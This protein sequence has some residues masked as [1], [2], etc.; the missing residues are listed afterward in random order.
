MRTWV[1]VGVLAVLVGLWA[2]VERGVVWVIRNGRCGESIGCEHEITQPGE[3]LSQWGALNEPGW[4]RSSI[5]EYERSHIFGFGFE[6]KEWD[7]YAIM[8]PDVFIG[9][10]I[11]DMGYIS[12]IA[13]SVIPLQGNINGLSFGDTYTAMEIGQ[14]SPKL[15]T[16][17][18]DGI[19]IAYRGGANMSILA[20]QEQQQTPGSEGPGVP[21]LKKKISLEW[22]AYANNL[23][24][25]VALEIESPGSKDH[26]DSTIAVATPFHNGWRHFYYNV[27]TNCMKPR[28]RVSL[29]TSA[30]FEITPEKHWA[31]LDWG[32]GL[33][34]YSVQWVWCSAS[35]KATELND[36]DKSPVVQHKF[37]LNFG[38]GFGDL[39]TH[40]ENAVFVDGITYKLGELNITYSRNNDWTQPWHVSDK[41]GNIN[42]VME[43]IHPRNSVDSF[44][45][46]S[47][48]AHQVLGRWGGTVRLDTGLVLSI[49]YV[50]G[51]SEHVKNKW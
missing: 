8:G 50:Y 4:S 30:V 14:S 43:P 45:V 2:G 3:L 28:G 12:V 11:A 22:P 15:P 24:L 1:V 36:D 49:N 9:L 13:G 27:K 20:W 48:E 18:H 51:W 21:T 32:R 40:T 7:Y 25:S 38:T 35:G 33:W 5:L 19:S 23:G 26:P 44:V 46:V 17:P 41:L 31:T 39:S 47:M 6:V 16:S 29:G 42:L 34:P 10:T 37:G